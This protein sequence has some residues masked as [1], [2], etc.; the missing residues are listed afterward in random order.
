MEYKVFISSTVKDIDLA[1]DLAQRIKGVGVKVYSVEKNA[2][3]GESI[4]K[5]INRDLRDADEVII[6]LTDSSIN[7]PGLISEIGAAFGLGKQVTP[8]VLGV[9]TGEI[10]SIIKQMNYIKYDQLSK[11]ISN[12]ERRVK[13]A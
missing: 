5:K 8:V 1:R 2:V 3:A 13:A 11:Y 9:G 4:V 10:P 7:N 6:L 12:L